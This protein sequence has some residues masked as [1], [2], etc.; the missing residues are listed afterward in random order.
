MTISVLFAQLLGPDTLHTENFQ[1]PLATDYMAEQDFPLPANHLTINER[2]HLIPLPR[3]V[4]RFLE[5]AAVA[6]A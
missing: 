1:R 2:T 5:S 3:L 6:N 4:S